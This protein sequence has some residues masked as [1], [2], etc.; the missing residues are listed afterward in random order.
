MGQEVTGNKYTYSSII[1]RDLGSGVK[2]G[3]L[4]CRC[5]V[6]PM[7]AFVWKPDTLRWLLG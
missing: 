6:E 4:R 5:A 3:T 2:L 7:D 1:N